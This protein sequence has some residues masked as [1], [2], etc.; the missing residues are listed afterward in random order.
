MRP[1]TWWR[2]T[3]QAS[4]DDL[5]ASFKGANRGERIARIGLSYLDP[6][7]LRDLPFAAPQREVTVRADGTRRDQNG[8]DEVRVLA[9]TGRGAA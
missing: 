4:F 6:L 5:Q 3:C 1:A 2:L 7:A 9:P 8:R